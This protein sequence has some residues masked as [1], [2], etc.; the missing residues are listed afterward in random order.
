MADEKERNWEVD[1]GKMGILALA[2]TCLTVLGA[3][4]IVPGEAVTAIFT[5]VVGYIAGNGVNA[6]RG[7]PTKGVVNTKESATDPD[8]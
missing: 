7:K 1:L 2:L 5:T 3:L 6:M 8:E 4:H